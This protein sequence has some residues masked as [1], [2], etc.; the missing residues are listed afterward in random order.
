M[1]LAWLPDF[2][3]SGMPHLLRQR[4]ICKLALLE[5]KAIG[6]RETIEPTG[7]SARQFQIFRSGHPN[8]E[9]VNHTPPHFDSL[10][11]KKAVAKLLHDCIPVWE[12]AMPAATKDYLEFIDLL[13]AYQF[14]FGLSYRGVGIGA[15]LFF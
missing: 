15:Q 10:G 7:A 12:M 2:F 11:I 5:R 4:E 3:G 1:N 6:N 14:E 13:R 9:R 8:V